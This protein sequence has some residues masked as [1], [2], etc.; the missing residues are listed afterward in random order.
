MTELEAL[1]AM[2]RSSLIRLADLLEAN[3]LAPPF[4]DLT[5]QDHI[6]ESHV[7][8]VSACLVELTRR[9]ASPSQIALVLRA[10]AAGREVDRDVSELIDV[11]VSGPDAAAAARDTGVVIRQLFNKARERVL[12]VGFAI[13][14]G[15]S[16]FQTLAERL[17]TC[18]AS[19]KTR[20][21]EVP[22]LYTCER[23]RHGTETVY[24]TQ[25]RVRLDL[26]SSAL[27]CAVSLQAPPV[28]SI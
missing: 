7:T 18:E 2:D 26:Q 25:A 19:R 15:R 16:V 21:E 13:H 9:D 8:S 27:T 22:A 28:R 14:Q 24:C 3:L 10:F 11:V 17:D 1:N 12:A 6:A 23:Y 4:G 5:L 20:F